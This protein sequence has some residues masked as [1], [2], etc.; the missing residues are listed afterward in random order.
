MVST[1]R[2]STF[3]LVLGGF[4]GFPLRL[5]T[6]N[7]ALGG[8]NCSTLRCSAFNLVLRFLGRFGCRCRRVRS[9]N[10]STTDHGLLL[11]AEPGERKV[12]SH[13]LL[14]VLLFVFP[15]LDRKGVSFLG[16]F[17]FSPFQF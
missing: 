7:L 2:F 11:W 6:V 1:L 10:R 8:F 13:D 9:K 5:Y 14:L 3:N 17:L 4:P 15:L 12:R 16:W